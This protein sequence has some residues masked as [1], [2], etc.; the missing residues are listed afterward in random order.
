MSTARRYVRHVLRH[1]GTC[2]NKVA[3]LPLGPWWNDV[4]YEDRFLMLEL[5]SGAAIGTV[6]RMT[7]IWITLPVLL[8]DVWLWY[9]R[10]GMHVHNEL[11]SLKNLRL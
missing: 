6:L 4:P 1:Y 5:L 9:R 7:P 11:R 8:L 10:E 3:H 2:L